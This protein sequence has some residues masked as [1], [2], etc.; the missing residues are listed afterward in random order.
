MSTVRA[1]GFGFTD[2]D[3]EI[4]DES[5]P[6]RVAYLPV[7][8]RGGC[9]AAVLLRLLHLKLTAAT[10]A[11][12]SGGG[13]GSR[14]RPVPGKQQP[15]QPQQPTGAARAALE[16]AFASFASL[17]ADGVAEARRS[18]PP[19]EAALACLR[20]SNLLDIVLHDVY[21]ADARQ[22][23]EGPDLTWASRGAA[24]FPLGPF[25]AA[26]VVEAMV[27]ARIASIHHTLRFR[28]HHHRSQ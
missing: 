20:A 10:R 7:W 3:L 15:Q 23:P 1:L 16:R 22:S 9:A 4:R 25:V 19:D 21:P 13:G 5:C 17:M 26:G 12:G 18:L 27:R 2:T 14:R 8:Q 6:T 11:G 24:Q 28:H